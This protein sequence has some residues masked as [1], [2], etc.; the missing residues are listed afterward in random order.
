MILCGQAPRHLYVANR[1]CR[2]AR[3]LAIVHEDGANLSLKTLKRRLRPDALASKVTRWLSDRRRGTA[4][5]EA[6][7]F[8]GE[9]NPALER[10][11]LAVYVPHINHQDVTAL[12]DRLMPDVIAVFGTSLIR[13]PLLGKGRLG[14]INLHG[15]LS[16]HY[17]G[18]DGIFWAL[19]NGE[20]DA[21]GCTLHFVNAGI[22]TGNLIAHVC[23]EIRE[24]DDELTIFWRAVKDASETFAEILHRLE[25]R[26]R[27]GQR[28]T[29]K[30]RLYRAKDRQLR[31]ERELERR[32]RD[33]LLSGNRLPARIRWFTSEEAP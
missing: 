10:P 16:P 5:A 24:D 14:M 11:E 30:G 19:F 2:G 22:D 15:G 26:E 3:P 12:A 28:Q 32:L 29:A 21:A 31:H 17:R 4:A 20:P 23:P 25:K 27:L 6:K 18:A 9:E 7:F 33:G 8:F 13:P 1:L